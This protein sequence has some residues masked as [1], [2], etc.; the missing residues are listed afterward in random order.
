MHLPFLPPGMFCSLANSSSRCQ[1]TPPN[2][3][4][5]FLCTP[6]TQERGTCS[7]LPLITLNPNCPRTADLPTPSGLATIPASVL[8][9]HWLN[10]GINSFVFWTGEQSTL[11][12]AQTLPEDLLLVLPLPG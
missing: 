1:L 4:G 10:K 8:N 9:Q 6:Y 11:L 3:Q 5:N 2:S 12:K 7:V